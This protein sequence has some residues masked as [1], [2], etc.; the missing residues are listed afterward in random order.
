[1]EFLERRATRAWNEANDDLD[2]YHAETAGQPG[3]EE[4]TR[5]RY[6]QA[7]VDAAYD[8]IPA[9]YRD[10]RD[11]EDEDFPAAFHPELGPLAR[12]L[13][14]VAVFVPSLSAALAV[15]A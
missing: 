8:K 12:L 15:A 2:A 9:R 5:H 13:I 3:A 11:Q 14:A 10:P 1:M 6:L 7:D 4:T